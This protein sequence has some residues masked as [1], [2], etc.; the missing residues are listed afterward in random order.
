MCANGCH[1]NPE[2]C[3]VAASSGRLDNLQF[4][5]RVEVRWSAV[6][7]HRAALNNHLKVLQWAYDNGCPWPYKDRAKLV[8]NEFISKEI[9]EWVRALPMTGV[10][11]R[12]RKRI[13]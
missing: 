7:C 12:K 1:K 6:V 2:A 11:L 13:D 4:L 3:T 10:L 5:R 9:R 8:D